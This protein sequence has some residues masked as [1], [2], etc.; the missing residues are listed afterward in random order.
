MA[1]TEGYGATLYQW[2]P[3]APGPGRRRRRAVGLLVGLVALVAGAG[4]PAA[5]AEQSTDFRL[6]LSEA[7]PGYGQMTVVAPPALGEDPPPP[8]RVQVLDAVT[9]EPIEATVERL[10]PSPLE[11]VVVADVG[12]GPETVEAIQRGLR[13][14]VL[15]LPEGTAVAIVSAGAEAH[16]VASLTRSP[17]AALAGLALL[18]PTAPGLPEAAIDLGLDQLT[19][20]AGTRPIVVEVR[21]GSYASA[22]TTAGSLDPT[23][24]RLTEEG[25]DVYVAHLGTRLPERSMP[26]PVRGG[27]VIEARSAPK[28]RGVLDT[29]ALDLSL[30]RYL[31]D[32]P[33]DDVRGV[34]LRSDWRSVRSEVVTVAGPRIDPEPPEAPAPA[35]GPPLGKLAAAVG[36]LALVVA[37][38][39]LPPWR[40]RRRAAREAAL[41]PR[42]AG[43]RL[44]PDAAAVPTTPTAV[45][46][47][48][49]GG[50][51]VE[52]TAAV[53]ALLETGRRSVSAV[54][55]A[56]DVEPAVRAELGALAE[57]RRVPVR[58]G[59]RPG[60]A[61]PVAA[62]ASPLA[63]VS[64]EALWSGGP[65]A[66]HVALAGT[67]TSDE[68][69]RALQ[70]V[71][72][73]RQGS[74]APGVIL[75][76]QPSS[77][78]TAATAAAA[79]GAVEHL[80]FALVADL[81]AALAAARS[82]GLRVVGAVGTDH[83][84]A[85][86]A[87]EL[88]GGTVVVLA[89]GGDLDRSVRARCDAVVALGGVDLAERVEQVVAAVARGAEPSGPVVDLR[90]A[91]RT[92]S[93]S[94]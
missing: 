76:R 35:S 25:V 38:V 78:I 4:S 91:G 92:S 9:E 11:V 85:E 33:G 30:P 23:R 15:S 84:E 26:V 53:R 52:G 62:V 10:P 32:V 65:G 83:A 75:P 40:R 51:E 88:R 72:G 68:L 81:G 18:A 5:A 12:G 60:A 17:D 6:S 69:G 70:A 34:L 50:A 77:R 61:L 79:G 47:T 56:D 7:K 24:D 74:G 90:E 93:L 8:D 54:W 36:G 2:S 1:R 71:A 28:L 73:I 86:A 29:F 80:S 87:T 43:V 39:L 37:V 16:L 57:R 63:Q 67:P 48:G 42:P 13:E 3:A 31:I 66:V 27:M 49:L 59:R 58:S 46:E 82:A 22:T 44:A 14:F 55:I 20:T 41:P 89:A 19:G 21:T 94:R 64:L 45:V